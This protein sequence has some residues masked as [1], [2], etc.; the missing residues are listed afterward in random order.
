MSAR[1]LLR[2]GEIVTVAVELAGH[3]WAFFPGRVAQLFATA[4]T[5]ITP[6]GGFEFPDEWHY[7]NEGLTWCRGTDARSM[8]ALQAAV[9]LVL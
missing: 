2:R 7:D 9:A 1:V 4:F 5:V 8:A 3:N 6:D